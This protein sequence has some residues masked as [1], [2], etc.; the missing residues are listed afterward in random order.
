MDLITTTDRL[1][2][3][4]TRLAHHPYITVDTDYDNRQ[5]SLSFKHRGNVLWQIG[6]QNDAANTFFMHDIARMRDFLRVNSSGEM[7]MTTLTAPT[8]AGAPRRSRAR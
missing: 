7:S 3:A 1:A 8:P 4:C 2:E 6:K 5:T